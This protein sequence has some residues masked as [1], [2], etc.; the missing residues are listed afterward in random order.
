MR[1]ELIKYIK[2]ENKYI[3]FFSNNDRYIVIGWDR[4]KNKKV[5]GI[6]QGD[7]NEFKI[8]RDHLEFRYFNT[9]KDAYNQ[10]IK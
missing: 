6:I 8:Y 9:Y 1:N 4:K 2:D 7:V 3:N 10:L 5:I